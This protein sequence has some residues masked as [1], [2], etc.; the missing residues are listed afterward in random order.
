MRRTRVGALRPVRDGDAQITVEQRALADYDTA[1]G[2]DVERRRV[3][4]MTARTSTSTATPTHLGG[5]WPARWR[6]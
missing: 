4:V 6:S 1:F 2:L 3:R 5:T